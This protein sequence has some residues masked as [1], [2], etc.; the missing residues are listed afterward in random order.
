MSDSLRS[1]SNLSVGGW[2]ELGAYASPF[3][4]TGVEFLPMGVS[5]ED[6]ELV[7]HEAGY[8]PRRP[9]WNYPNVFTPY[10]RLY[11]DFRSGHQVVFPHREVPLGPDRFVLI[12][13]HQL[14]S[15]VGT[16]PRPHFWI[17]FSYSEQPVPGQ[18]VPFELSPGKTEVSLVRDITKLLQAT[19][20]HLNR[21]RIYHGALALLHLLLS[22]P[23]IQWLRKAPEKLLNVI[24]YIESHYTSPLSGKH[25]AE[26]AHMSQSVFR[27]QFHE[28]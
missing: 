28:L 7:L 2:A 1:W 4:G 12:P 19:E 24:R 27:R 8:L 15:T 23:E 25:L 9:H 11:Y 26:I 21:Q 13:T 10:W 16:E 3:S 5:P 20:G 17:A 18:V 14:F 22:R 6:G